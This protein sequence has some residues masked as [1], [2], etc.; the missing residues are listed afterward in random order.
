MTIIYCSRREILDSDG[1]ASK[2]TTVFGSVIL[3]CVLYFILANGVVIML[4]IAV[5]DWLVR[6]HIYINVYI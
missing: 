3:S 4:K 1:R 6:L 5:A 2:F